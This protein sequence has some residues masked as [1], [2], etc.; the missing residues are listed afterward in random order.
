MKRA[1]TIEEFIRSFDEAELVY[2]ELGRTV[3]R[4]IRR[5]MTAQ[6]GKCPKK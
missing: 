2:F 6:D 5:E 3:S 1:A 4:I